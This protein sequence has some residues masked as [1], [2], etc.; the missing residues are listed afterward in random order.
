MPP[1]STY[2]AL[3]KNLASFPYENSN[4]LEATCRAAAPSA[5]R[6]FA[7]HRSGLVLGWAALGQGDHHVGPDAEVPGWYLN[8]GI[9]GARAMITKEEPTKLQ[10][11][12]VFKSS[13]AYGKLEAGDKLT[14]ANKNSFSTAHKFGHGVGKFGYQGPIMDFGEALEESQGKL[15]GRLT[16]DV[17]RGDQKLKVDLQVPT[18]YGTYSANYPFTCKKSDLLLKKSCDWLSNAQLPDGTWSSR[19]HINAFAALAL[20]GSGDARYMPEV[21][22]AMRAMAA[23][24]DGKS[25]RG[26]LA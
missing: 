6:I 7:N 19:P 21:R 18:E 20:L 25:F 22:K 5:G 9:T 13:P 3:P 16:L 8:L 15:A 24:T 23:A 2:P 26:L 4:H 12:F 17:Q 11:M 14:G 10:V 1:V